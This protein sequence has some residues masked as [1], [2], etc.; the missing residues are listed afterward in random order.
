MSCHESVRCDGVAR[1]V[2]GGKQLRAA[3][4]HGAS[5]HPAI[6]SRQVKIG[7]S[8][9]AIAPGGRETVQINLTHRGM[10]LLRSSGPR[11]LLATLTGRGVRSRAVRLTIGKGG[12]RKANAPPVVSA[13]EQILRLLRSL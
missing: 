5:H 2:V 11:G 6:A 1:L 4:R 10:A 13:L 12:G 7:Q 9:F 3:K 8:R